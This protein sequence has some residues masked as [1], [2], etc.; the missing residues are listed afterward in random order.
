MLSPAA[1]CCAAAGGARVLLPSSRLSSAAARRPPS[2]P[3][4][5]SHLKQRSKQLT[6]DP[7]L[8][9]THADWL[10]R[11]GS[12]A[13]LW[14]AGMCKEDFARP[15][16]TVAAPWMNVQM[17]VGPAP[18]GRPAARGR[19][20]GVAAGCR[21]MLASA[22]HLRASGARCGPPPLTRCARPFP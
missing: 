18:A 13:Q 22:P 3:R 16:I 15:I 17:C 19:P 10:R 1:R 9:P 20:G 5:L 2:E 21:A 12:R 6:G 4:D 8:G 14:G 7:A 11:S